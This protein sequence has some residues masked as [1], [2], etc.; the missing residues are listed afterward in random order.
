VWEVVFRPLFAPTLLPDE[1]SARTLPQKR[2]MEGS[3]QPVDAELLQ[4]DPLQETDAQRQIGGIQV[5]IFKRGR[6]YWYNFWWD[7]E[8]IQASTGKTDPNEAR[9]VEASR[10]T[11]L[12]DEHKER[13]KKARNLGCEPDELI[14]C[15]GCEKWFNRLAA[16]DTPYGKFCG[17]PCRDRWEDEHK[18]APTLKE[19][20]QRFI[21]EIEVRCQGKPNTVQFYAIKLARLLEFEPLASARLDRIDEELISAFIQNRSHQKSRAGG[22]RKRPTAVSAEKPISPASVNRELATLRRL[23]RMANEWKVINRVPRIRLLRGER[24]REFVLSHA[25]ERNYLEFAPQP[26]KDAGLLMLDTGLRVGELRSLEW[27]DVHLQPVGDA[28]FGFIHVRKGKSKNA[29]RN[30]SLSPRVRAML[31]NR[32]ASSQSA[33]VFTDDTGSKPLSIWTMEDQHKRMRQA[34]KLPAD[35]VIHSFRHTFGTR[36]GETGAD[37]FTIMKVMGHSTVV[38]SQKY[39]H[40]TPETME[41]AFERLNAASEK[42]LASLPGVTQSQPTNRLPTTFSTAD[43][44]SETVAIKKVL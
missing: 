18:P 24:S 7:G 42:A 22:N 9:Q 35:A 4:A 39:V 10:K 44:E 15:V 25:Q 30:V 5:A 6:V 13:E 31:D 43:L 37:A 14:C 2:G 12:G 28:K 19:F 41:R 36:L 8:H 32:K 3:P 34:L 21:D 26:L 16:V 38:V 40:P 23:L 1:V 17:Q 33:Y 11:E 20:A 27:E 29:K